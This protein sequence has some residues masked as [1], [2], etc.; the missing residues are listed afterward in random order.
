MKIHKCF[1]CKHYIAKTNT[2]IAFQPE[3]IPIE[4]ARV[5]DKNEECAKGYKFTPEEESKSE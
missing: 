3:K 2:C 4:I 5:N 1:Y